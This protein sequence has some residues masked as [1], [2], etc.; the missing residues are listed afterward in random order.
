MQHRIN[1]H[2]FIFLTAAIIFFI[3]FL[4]AV[5]YLAGG[6]PNSYV[7]GEIFIKYT[8]GFIRRGLIGAVLFQLSG[9][10]NPCLLWTTFITF[11]YAYF[12]LKVYALFKDNINY[13]FTII[14]FFSPG[15]IAFSV[16]DKYLFGR[17]DI[18][19]LLLIFLI[20]SQCAKIIK[21]QQASPCAWIKI[22]VCYA[23][24]FLAH[25]ITLFFSLLPALLVVAASG[26]KKVLAA[27]LIFIAF[28]TS[29]FLAVYFQGTEAIRDAMIANWRSVIPN[30][31]TS[32]GMEYIGTSLA[33]NMNTSDEWLKS[34]KFVKSYIYAWLLT[35]L[36]ILLFMYVYNFHHISI[37]VIGRFL[38]WSSYLCALF[39]V[40]TLTKLINDFGRI[41]SYSSVIFII[42]TIFII[43]IYKSKYGDI[44]TNN[45]ASILDFQNIYVLIP[46]VYYL[47]CW[48]LHHWVPLTTPS[49]I[50]S[51]F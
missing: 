36:P 11:I 10:I 4:Y 49:I 25:E 21:S 41:I 24:S 29:V 6:Y 43:S 15:L 17:K 34:Y 40:I 1:I 26:R 46:S 23:L 14:L 51:F 38:T 39:P 16:K 32:G 37:R 47:L 31:T 27:A 3:N 30:F 20:M 48:K 19:I 8:D 28:C 33:Q 2:T 22:A 9:I 18:L 44:K 45:L 13:F 12:F 50:S 35:L 42:Y 5:S 7:W